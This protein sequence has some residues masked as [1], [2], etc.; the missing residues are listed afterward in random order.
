MRPWL[1]ALCARGSVVAVAQSCGPTE[2]SRTCAPEES[3]FYRREAH[4]RL[5]PC[6]RPV[7]ALPVSAAHCR[8]LSACHTVLS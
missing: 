4:R 6:D 5:G 8:G 1:I 7:L 3:L 2:P